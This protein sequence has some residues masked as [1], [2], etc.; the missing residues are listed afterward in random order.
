MP[1]F[2]SLPRELRD[3]IYSALLTQTAPLITL[4]DTHTPLAW[5]RPCEAKS[6]L[7]DHGCAFSTKKAPRTCASFLACNHQV[8]KELGQAIEESRR[9]GVLAAQMDCLVRD[10]M[11]WFS[12][13]I[14]PIVQ[15][16]ERE[17]EYEE[18]GMVR[19]A[20]GLVSGWAARMFGY[21]NADGRRVVETTIETLV[22]D[23]RGF[24]TLAGDDDADAMITPAF[25]TPR[26]RTSWA[27][28]AALKYVVDWYAPND[29]NIDE[30]VLNVLPPVSSKPSSTNSQST[31]AND[32]TTSPTQ[33]LL[34]DLVSVW[35]S[36]WAANEFK[37][38]YYRM[39]LERVKMVRICEDGRTWRVRELG[40][41]L[42]RGRMERKR[43][44]LRMY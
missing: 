21:Q 26:D 18:K 1:N 16:L 7:G 6:H 3:M 2:L 22:V 23:I 4:Q 42:R 36:L 41:E 12:W 5:C 37:A 13:G 39:L 10:G 27:V 28:C 43:I 11:H 25:E 31:T 15:T 40:V 17:Q 44:E 19:F 38:R 14:V 29:I 20:L 35:A 34:D 9:K 24:D 30:L 33:V 8:Y 32:A